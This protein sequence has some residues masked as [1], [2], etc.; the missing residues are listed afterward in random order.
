MNYYK[1]MLLLSLFVFQCGLQT[2]KGYVEHRELL[3]NVFTFELEFGA[4]NLPDEFL[5]VRPWAPDANDSGDVFVSDESRIKV[6]DK[7]GKAKM[8]IGR[9]GQGPGEFPAL[10]TQPKISP[11]GYLTVNENTGFSVFSPE[12][13]FIKRVVNRQGIRERYSELLKRE[14]WSPLINTSGTLSLDENIHVYKGLLVSNNI[15]LIYEN[16]DSLYVIEDY[17]A[18]LSMGK[19]LFITLGIKG[20][21]LWVVPNKDKIFYLHTDHDVFYENDAHRYRLNVFSFADY[22]YDDHEYEYHPVSIP[23]SILAK[24]KNFYDSDIYGTGK[25]TILSAIDDTKYYPPLKK[26]YT[27]RNLIFA[28]TFYQNDTGEYFTDVIDAGTGEKIKSVYF[29]ISPLP[30]AIKNGYAYMIGVNDDGFFVIEKYKI[31]PAVY[32]R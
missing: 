5:I 23:D 29:Y 25:R 6:Y 19:G 27:D 24:E 2:E 31:N 18:K 28:V 4:D 12:Y 7:N 17:A 20:D 9:P 14:G 8:I 30:H 16:K 10:V 26:L 22:S 13:K 15:P 1:L 32:E 21:L 3:S 11:T